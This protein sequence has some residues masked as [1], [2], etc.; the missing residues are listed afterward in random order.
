MEGVEAGL[1]DHCQSVIVGIS[2]L[3]VLGPEEGEMVKELE[4][5]VIRMDERWT[6]MTT[7]NAHK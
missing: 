4:K 5:L 3:L 1:N 6:K 7:V 2:L